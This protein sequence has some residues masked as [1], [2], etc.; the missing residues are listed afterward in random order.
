MPLH[1]PGVSKHRESHFSTKKTITTTTT[2]T[3]ITKGRLG[4]RINPPEE[5][6]EA[7]KVG[8]TRK[9]QPRPPLP[10]NQPKGSAAHLP[11]FVNNW[12]KVCTNNFILRI[13]ANGY[14]IPFISTPSQDE[15]CLNLQ[16]RFVLK[17]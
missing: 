17:M 6:E 10:R 16:H 4:S 15:F 3:A 11:F 13:V 9:K 8:N 7:E 1:Y 14:N 5:E 2:T 12:T